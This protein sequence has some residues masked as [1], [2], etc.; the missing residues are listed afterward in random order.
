MVHRFDG[1]T[2]AFCKSSDEAAEYVKT[3]G[4]QSAPDYDRALSWRLAVLSMPTN[5]RTVDV[6]VHI[7][8][9]PI[10]TGRR[11]ANCV[12]HGQRWANDGRNFTGRQVYDQNGALCYD[13]E[14]T[15]AGS[16]V[17]SHWI[18]IPRGP[19]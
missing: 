2:A 12:W 4:S 10:N 8:G 9:R 1:S 3:Y 15:D 13:C 19:S 18:D 11:I 16:V 17:V 7:S 6:W 14:L 5:S